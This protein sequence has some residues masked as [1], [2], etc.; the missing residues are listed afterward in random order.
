MKGHINKLVL[1]FLGIQFF[2]CKTTS[3]TNNSESYQMKI[4]QFDNNYEDLWTQVQK[5]EDDG[6]YK[7]ALTQVEVIYESAKTEGNTNQIIKSSLYRVKYQ[8]YLAD[9]SF[10]AS[11]KELNQLAKESETPQKEILHSI[12]GAAY[13]DY[14]TRNQWRFYER[15]TLEI[16]ESDDITTWSL[17]RIV[18][19]IH[20]HYDLSLANK[21]QTQQIS[22]E[23]F[24]MILTESKESKGL[25]PTLYD[26]LA[27]RALEFY[28]NQ[29][30]DVIRPT[31]AFKLNQE[32]VF[33]TDQTFTNIRLPQEDTLS[34]KRKAFGIYQELI[35][36]HR[37]K[38]KSTRA[39][40]DAQLHQLTFA[41]T[42]STIDDKEDRYLN[43]LLKL[44]EKYA[45]DSASAEVSYYIA[46]AYQGKSYSENPENRCMKKKAHDVCVA[47]IKKFPTSYGANQCQG[48]K[49]QL[50]QKR[51]DINTNGV[52]IPNEY[53]KLFLKTT[54]LSKVYLKVVEVNYDNYEDKRFD[55]YTD[56]V[57]YL[58][59]QKVIHSWD[60][61]I[62]D[63]GDML[64]KAMDVL[65]KPLTHGYYVVCASDNPSF[66]YES[67]AVHVTPFW[68]ST[69]Y[70]INRKDKN[71]QIEF[72]VFDRKSGEI[73]T[74]VSLK[75]SEMKYS[76][77]SDKNKVAKVKNY[78]ANQE[79]R[80]VLERNS[81]KYPNLEVEFTRPNGDRW[82][83]KHY[84]RWYDPATRRMD[85]GYLFT[86]RGIYRPGQTIY[87]K[88]ILFDKLENEVKVQ[89]NQKVKI[90][91]K[92]VNYQEVAVLNLTTNDFGSVQGQF[93]IPT[94]L[95]NGSMTLLM[96]IDN[97]QVVYKNL[98]VEEYK[99]PKFEVSFDP[100]KGSYKLNSEIKTTGLA[101]AYAGNVIDGAEVTYRVVR[102]AQFPWWCWYRFGYRPD[103]P[104]MEITNGT[105]TTNEKGAFEVVFNAISDDQVANK[106]Q[107]TYSF[108]ITADVTDL[109]GETH[110]S[111]QTV[112]VSDIAL[113]MNLAIPND[114]EVNNK[115][116]YYLTTSNLNGQ[117]VNTKGQLKIYK[118]INLEGTKKIRAYQEP[119]YFLLS[120]EEHDKLFPYERYM[121]ED[122]SKWM[123]KE[124]YS[125]DFATEE[126]KATL[127]DL[128]VMK[129]FVTGEYELE[130]TATD[131]FNKEVKEI[132]WF[133]VY[134]NSAAM[135]QKKEF[136]YTQV[137]SGDREPGNT[138]EVIVG[139]SENNTKVL[140]EVEHKEAIVRKE[141]ITLSNAQQKVTIPI[142]EKHRGDF[143][144]HFTTV[145]EGEFYNETHTIY[146]PFINK[147]LE[148]SFET[149][150]DKLFPG[151]K[152][153]WTMK[154]KG[155]KG[156]QVVSELLAS[157]YDASLDEFVSNNYYMSLYNSTYARLGWN[158]NN[159]RVVSGQLISQYW[160]ESMENR[161]Y[162]RYAQLNMFGVYFNSYYRER[163]YRTINAPSFDENLDRRNYS[164][165][166][167]DE[168]VIE[169][170]L[171]VA[172]SAMAPM[173]KKEMSLNGDFDGDGAFKDTE[174]RGQS[175]AQKPGGGIKPIKARTNFNETAFFF[176]Q[177]K[178][179]A[180]GDVTISF[181]VPESLTKWKFISLAHTPDG[182]YG[183]LT[184]NVVTQKDL[185]VVPNAPR[186]LRE[187]DKI[188]ISSKISN[189]AKQ[190]LS[191]TAVLTLMDAYTMQPINNLFQLNH[192]NKSFST[193]AG[194]STAVEW[195]ITIPEGVDAVVYKV[196]AQ[197][198][199]FSDGEQKAL[200]ILT[201]RMLVTE[202]L[203]LHIRK[204]G[205]KTF[206]FDKLVNNTSTTLK[207][208]SL[209]LEYTNNPTWYVI[210][211]MPYMMEYPYECA[212]QTFTRYYAN[213]IATHLMNSSPKIK[214]VIESWKNY[215]PD[216]FLSNLEKN[217]ELKAVIL[218]ET[219]WV[220]EANN[221][222]ERKKRIAELFNLEKMSGQS[223]KSL[224][225][226]MEMQSSSGGWSWFKGGRDN[227]Y[228]TQHIVTGIGH[229]QKLGVIDLKE[230]KEVWQMTKNAINY[231]DRMS[232]EEY[233]D[234]KRYYKDWE[235]TD[236]L[237]YNSIHYLYGRTFFN[238]LDMSKAEQ[239][240]FDYFL[241]QSQ[242]YWLSRNKYAQG[243][244]A[245]ANHRTKA[246]GVEVKNKITASLKE[247]VIKNDEFGAYWKGMMDGGYYWYQAPIETQALMIE[248]FDEVANDQEM[249]NDLKVW[250]LKQKQTTD[251]KTT[252]AT[253]EA[254]YALLLRGTDFLATTK[255]DKINV[256]NYTI[257][258]KGEK[259][260]KNG[261]EV[262][263]NEGTGYFKTTWEKE[264]INASMGKVTIKKEQDN[265]SW[266]SLY[267]QYFEELD[268]ITPSETPLSLKKQLFKSINTD[269]GVKL[270]PITS[271]KLS[272][273]DKVVVRIE[274]R[275][276]R[277]MEYIHMK[278]MRA[279]GFEPINVLSRYK[280]QDGLG[281]YETTKD[282][283]TNFFF[284]YLPRGT[285][286]F[287]Y[288]LRVSQKGAFSNGITSIQCMYAPEFSSHS[289]GVRVTVSE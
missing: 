91:L 140:F 176:P 271:E 188:V 251:W 47:A 131:A 230:N 149:F 233:N 243:M 76:Y 269:E 208:H 274:L 165:G 201:N 220:M 53:G 173:E 132:K 267:W 97:K 225:K 112:Y 94:G 180:Q 104:Q 279:S 139:A 179:N 123:K 9:D 204:A 24:D 164:E 147:D 63:E 2:G 265:V 222:T 106:Y 275:A 21:S 107:P 213:E 282:A 44:Q 249:V 153:Q 270:L 170:S 241:K 87:F 197:A 256:G 73:L 158:D 272:V 174:A 281:Y 224:K 184:K 162:R 115:H 186:F 229:L 200:P 232:L 50:E 252:K 238:Q 27:Y 59:K 90:L 212:E 45:N 266:G 217:Q 42:Y 163:R 108:T 239:Q 119:N 126:E 10:E 82:I 20:K 122:K 260:V 60:V 189:I 187:G 264:E 247:Q 99:R 49:I 18:E 206:T 121:P 29:E 226:L 30:P 268:K 79:G 253:A 273:G 96:F 8:Q 157:M 127:I 143:S 85:L 17:P 103:S 46:Q 38:T 194:Q 219:P 33:A 221:E 19:E 130:L 211:A 65:M 41:K 236:H 71:G 205:T 80:Y 214:Q 192:T 68:V 255:R 210:Q 51:L 191:G 215:S 128:A 28:E 287:E 32:E 168:Y 6:L 74:D 151:Q 218:E 286:V 195:N 198:G 113:K 102:N 284:D 98:Q 15:T 263:D 288:A 3:Q 78:P 144:I 142:E 23:S 160:N 62:N 37:N 95:L 190:D 154:I 124:V 138:V 209:T 1:L 227:R 57:D 259:S 120:K 196:T 109:N 246:D 55:K 36:L 105:T 185:M 183:T 216:E 110:S 207:H 26:V 156:D 66:T 148:L 116:E 88:G 244:I 61:T 261:K 145:K 182:K 93:N 289:E 84:Q 250:L 58:N 101:K 228:I 137:L 114:V 13:T 75:V 134:N 4:I 175:V 39:L 67:G 56:R 133:S 54:N 177:L 150:R 248:L 231:L 167:S 64:E 118:F 280:W 181:E 117:V 237:S 34:S 172:G 141:W 72:S 22:I 257:V 111:T 235:T 199:D 240:A 100:V 70:P 5:A 135:A 245:L 159:N 283:S 152:E 242:T 203:P 278:D 86:D 52:I 161:K 69:I 254:C 89:P 12:L 169:E 136:L 43:S 35:R 285:Y 83:E 193:K 146:V 31:Y 277:N 14:Y 155:P 178:T 202:S 262:N 166:E 25:R 11:I 234:I 7:S 276:D 16:I 48:L 92:D 258:Y 40:I 171:S 129:G 81:E 125:A 77:S 223:Q